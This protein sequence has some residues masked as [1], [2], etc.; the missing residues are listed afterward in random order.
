VSI[1]ATDIKSSL[2]KRR[3]QVLRFDFARFMLERKQ[4][5]LIKFMNL[6]RFGPVDIG[7]TFCMYHKFPWFSKISYD[8]YSSSSGFPLVIILSPL[9]WLS[10]HVLSLFYYSD[11]LFFLPIKYLSHADF[12]S[13]IFSSRLPA[14][15]WRF[16]TD[17]ETVSNKGWMSRKVRHLRYDMFW[18]NLA[19]LRLRNLA[20]SVFI[21]G[22]I[23]WIMYKGN[24]VFW[25]S[26]AEHVWA[27]LTVL[28]GTSMEQDLSK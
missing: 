17:S 20:A 21:L 18:R 12:S 4:D 13:S 11:R 2:E 15:T 28:F 14:R 6:S 1:A 9:S 26:L 5:I 3:P 25:S 23:L 8:F 7:V 19:A 22:Q 10:R 16:E 24:K 27:S